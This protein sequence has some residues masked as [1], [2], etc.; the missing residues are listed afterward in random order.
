MIMMT[1]ESYIQSLFAEDDK[2]LLETKLSIQKEDMPMISVSP[3][4]GKFLT[5]LIKMSG[6]TQLLEIGALG[7]YSGIC[8]L[9]GLSVDGHLTSLELKQEYADLAESNLKK[10]GFE[11]NV[12]YKIGPALDSL[13]ELNK[14]NRCFDFIFI[15]ADKGN[16]TNYLNGALKLGKPGTIIAADNTLRGGKITDAT[17]QEPDTLALREYNKIV[18]HHPQLESLLIPIGDGLTIARIKG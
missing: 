6:A 1:V 9:R 8:L 13:E 14:D 10:A 15:D 17:N 16:Y 7:G 2:I 4:S 18:A 3:E 5:L 12:T 11:N